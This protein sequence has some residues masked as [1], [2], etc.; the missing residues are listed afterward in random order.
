MN[1]QPS[2]P[3]A[4]P[5]ATEREVR[6]RLAEA[7]HDEPMPDEV[8]ARMDRTLAGLAGERA[9]EGAGGGAGSVSQDPAQD[10]AQ[11][12]VQEPVQDP[13][14][15]ALA[16]RRRRRVV[17]LLSAAAAVLVVGVGVNQVLG[18]S[19]D[20]GGAASSADAGASSAEAGD[21][22][23]VKA[24]GQQDAPS[25][26]TS[27]AVPATGFALDSPVRVRADHFSAD[28]ARARHLA[29]RAHG[30]HGHDDGRVGAGGA[31]PDD[32]PYVC[33]RA[34]W[35]RGTRVPV[36][37]DG[38]AAVLLLRPSDGDTQVVDL[39]GCGSDSVLRSI[40]LPS[41]G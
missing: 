27:L 13:A 9:P 36:L 26:T 4:S 12:P 16:S 29:A 33:P 24:R 17:G 41:R 34:H 14:V 31:G 32:E 25:D 2:R 20:G 10:P 22:D 38:R 18:P 15:V 30:W 11:E 5:E 40:T 6:R 19:R 21:G 3:T 28:V 23:A 35:G 8:A 1:D 39:F 7:R 37:Y